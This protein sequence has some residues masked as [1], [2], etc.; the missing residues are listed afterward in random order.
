ML[1]KQTVSKRRS[2][3]LN[4]FFNLIR[5]LLNKGW[6]VYLNP[7]DERK[8]ETQYVGNL[9]FSTCEEDL[10]LA[11]TG[12]SKLDEVQ[13]ENVTIAR[14]NGRSKYGFVEFSWPSCVPLNLADI[15]I[16]H[17]GRLQVNSRPIYFISANC[18]I[19]ATSNSILLMQ[20]DRALMD[21]SRAMKMPA[22]AGNGDDEQ[23]RIEE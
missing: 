5:V 21:R 19:R 16:R 13:V 17:S 14:V 9:D 6:S 1:S 4:D 10:E 12:N 11:I 8:T 23:V 2:S 15:C 22:A 7:K 3:C 20:Q 18:R